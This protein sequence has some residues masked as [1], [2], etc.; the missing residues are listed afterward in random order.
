MTR[1]F[2]IVVVGAGHAGSE[3]ALAGSRL[4]KRVALLTLNRRH[5]GR[6]SCNPA[7]GGLAKGHRCARWTPWAGPW[8]RWPTSAPCS[9][10]G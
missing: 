4:G 8:P 6:L 3:A 10:A 2:D 9:F 7:I 5:I 1:P